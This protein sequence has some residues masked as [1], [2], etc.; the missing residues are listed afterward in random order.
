MHGVNNIKKNV[1]PFLSLRYHFLYDNQ[2]L[3]FIVVIL[4]VH[5]CVRTSVDLDL[6]I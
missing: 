1:T 5:G 3:K 2:H 4:T 6:R